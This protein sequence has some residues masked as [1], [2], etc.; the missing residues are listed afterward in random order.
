[1]RLGQ[2]GDVSAVGRLLETYR[3]YLRCLARL[4][5]DREWRGKVDAADRRRTV[6]L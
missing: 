1:L 4:Q 3:G 6:T 2:N 5:I